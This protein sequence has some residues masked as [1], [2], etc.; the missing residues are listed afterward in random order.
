MT[1][2]IRIRITIGGCGNPGDELADISEYTVPEDYGVSV[3]GKG[4]YCNSTAPWENGIIELQIPPRAVTH[5]T[6][7]IRSLPIIREQIIIL[8]ELLRKKTLEK[9]GDRDKTSR[10]DRCWRLPPLTS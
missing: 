6:S 7:S 2:T 5:T 9:G 8:D 3:P 10:S 1:G 4:T